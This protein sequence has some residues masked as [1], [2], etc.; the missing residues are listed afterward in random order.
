[1][2]RMTQPRLGNLHRQKARS[3]ARDQ[4]SELREMTHFG[5]AGRCGAQKRTK[6]SPLCRGRVTLRPRPP[7]VL[8]ADQG[9]G[10]LDSAT[11]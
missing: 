1:M 8:P 2:S 3:K 5:A 6:A 11:I 9:P 10:V 4:N 7:T